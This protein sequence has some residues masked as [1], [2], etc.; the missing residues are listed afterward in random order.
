MRTAWASFAASGNPSTRAASWPPVGH[1]TKV[2]SFV[3]LQSKVTTDFAAAHHCS[4][5]AA[6]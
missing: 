1:G 3:P 5:W 4:F 2:L 6:G